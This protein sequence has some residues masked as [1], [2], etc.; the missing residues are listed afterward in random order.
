[1]KQ[2]TK[3][4][5]NPPVEG[6]KEIIILRIMAGLVFFWE[7]LIKF[8]FANQGVGRF[9]KLGFPM[10]EFTAHF[11]ATCEIVGGL[12]I[13]FGFLTRA[14]SF[15]FFFQMIIAILSTKISLWMGTY[16]LALPPV[17]PITGFWAVLHEVRSD[18]AQVLTSLFLILVGPG[19]LS[20]D[21]IRAAAKN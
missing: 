11:V 8:V 4:L 20:V 14:V 17:P 13:I 10:P 16:P 15:Y 21:K 1:M 12:C 5:F 19:T 18:F 9:T 6:P 7:G 2:F 3:W